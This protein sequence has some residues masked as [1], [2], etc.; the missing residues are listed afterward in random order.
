M[1]IE[2]PSPCKQTQPRLPECFFSVVTALNEKKNAGKPKFPPPFVSPLP[3][4]HTELHPCSQDL[5]LPSDSLCLLTHSEKMP[6]ADKKKSTRLFEDLFSSLFLLT[7]AKQDD[8]S[9]VLLQ[10]LGLD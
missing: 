8:T 7:A 9:A 10:L 1:N 5:R 2:S 4:P 3:S 6:E